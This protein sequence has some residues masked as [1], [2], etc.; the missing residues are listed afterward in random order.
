MTGFR[1]LVVDDEPLARGLV[2]SIV[3]RDAE[4]EQVFEAGEATLVPNLLAKHN[5]H[6]VFLDIEMPGMDGL[7]LARLIDDTGP[8][9][10]FITAFSRYAARAFDVSAVD[11]VM[12]P[13][14]DQRLLD[15]L[16]RAKRRVRE[17]RLGELANQVASLSA[18]LTGVK[19]GP[20]DQA[21]SY[22]PRLAFKS[23]DRA[24]VLKPEEI[25]WV[26]AEDYYVLIHSTRGR[27]LVRVPLASLEER[28]DP[29]LFVRVH[30][31]AIVNMQEVK[32]YDQ[33]EGAWLVMSDASRVPVSR[34]RKRRVE[35][36]LIPRNA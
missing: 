15:A 7:Q 33:R 23:G 31:A 35:E 20:R 2:A 18:E 29:Q 14:S 3:R 13:F 26:E 10:V 5:P 9:I 32:E 17:R 25:I 36:R 16:E 27:H 22:P 1:I 24:I 8:V 28:L 30:R 4:V 11:Y 21:P 6:I 34:S 12:K 19:E